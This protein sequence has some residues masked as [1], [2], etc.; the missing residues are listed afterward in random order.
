MGV[1]RL[2]VVLAG[3]ALLA[4]LAACAGVDASGRGSGKT[5]RLAYQPLPDGVLPAA[6]RPQDIIINPF[7]D[8]R[9]PG[10]LGVASNYGGHVFFTVRTDDD[11][12]AWITQALATEL[13]RT[14]LKVRTGG[15]TADPEACVVNGVV[16]EITVHGII[17]N[18]R[19][20]L[21][22]AKGFKV[23]VNASYN[24]DAEGYKG[25][26]FNTVYTTDYPQ[27]YAVALRNLM[28]QAVPQLV[29][30]L[31]EQPRE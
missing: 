26:W 21:Q 7:K 4:L 6:R 23:L 18:M 17:T 11:V 31:D 22:A 10:P 27:L 1:N 2:P 28:V 24:A 14:G 8:E 15:G 29:A 19:I 13:R 9:E 30:A 20:T 5:I 3:T 25:P 16:N 12:A